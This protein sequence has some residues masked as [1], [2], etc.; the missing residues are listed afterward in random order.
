MCC[1]PCPYMLCQ[2]SSSSNRDSSS[3]RI[4]CGTRNER[5]S[6]VSNTVSGKIEV[7]NYGVAE[8]ATATVAS[9]TLTSINVI[10]NPVVPIPDTG[11]N[12]ATLYLTPGTEQLELDTYFDYNKEYLS[13]PLTDEAESLYFAVDSDT[14]IGSNTDSIAIGTTWEE[15]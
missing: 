3:V 11:I 8:T 1:D 15:Q 2:R 5:F 12:I 6:H 13:F 14:K 7:V 4:R 9:D 10:N